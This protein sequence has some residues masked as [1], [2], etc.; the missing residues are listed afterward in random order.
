[1]SKQ[2]RKSFQQDIAYWNVKDLA[3]G[4]SSHKVLR[5]KAFSLD[6]NLEHDGYLSGLAPMIYRFFLVKSLLPCK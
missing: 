2:T 6:E 5:N 4:T 1:M 3:R